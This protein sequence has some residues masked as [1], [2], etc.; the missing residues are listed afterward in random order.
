[1]NTPTLSIINPVYNEEGNVLNLYREIRQVIKEKNY[2]AEIIFIDDGSQDRTLEILKSLDGVSIIV[3]RKNFG[4]TAALDAGFKAA[5]GEVIVALDGDGQNDPAD[6]PA[7][8]LELNHGYDVISG[9]RHNRQDKGSVKYF[10]RFGCQLRRLFIGDNIHD[11]G[12]TL[13]AY[14]RECFEDVDLHGEMHRYIHAVLKWRGFKIGEVKVNHRPRSS[15]KSH[16]NWKKNIKGFVDLLSVWF[17]RKYA[18]RPLHLFGSLGILTSLLGFVLLVLLAILR[19]WFGYG[20]SNRIW[21]LIAV[22]FILV[23]VQLFIAG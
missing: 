14:R 15:G 18:T 8:L 16:Y 19:L 17:W 10:S 23:G 21:P 2:A 7:L 22:F 3:F 4:Q 11:A 6:I 13:K 20:L 5:K 12:C 1:M 9:W